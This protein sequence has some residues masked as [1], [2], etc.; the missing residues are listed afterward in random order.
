MARFL[1]RTEYYHYAMQC[2][3]GFQRG[4]EHAREREKEIERDRKREREIAPV[5]VLLVAVYLGY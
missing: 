5:L 3:G 1:I 2:V 4:R